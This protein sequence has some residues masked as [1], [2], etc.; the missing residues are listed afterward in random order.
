MADTRE[1]RAFAREV[2]FVVDGVLGARIR[3]WAR[4]HLDADSHGSGRFGDTY[5]T[6]SL[7]FDTA[8][9]DVFHRRGSFGHAKY[10]IRR[11]GDSGTVFLERKLRKAAML[12]KR[13]AMVGI[14]DLTRLEDL[15]DGARDESWPGGWFERRVLVRRLGPVCQLSY[16]R[17]ARG[18][19]A[20]TGLARLTVD[21]CIHAARIDSVRFTDDPGLP[22]LDGCMI[23]ELKFRT[24]M[25]AAFKELIEECRLTPQTASKY[26]LGMAT[27]GELALANVTPIV[28]PGPGARV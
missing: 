7:Y 25:P 3:D 10:R 6:T 26:R 19:M 17:V 20:G 4:M 9:H 13:R 11:Y 21:E 18:V 28:S 2:K 1:T 5:Q 8:R 15:G 23:V 12:V 27:F 14:E 16:R 22:I 24:H